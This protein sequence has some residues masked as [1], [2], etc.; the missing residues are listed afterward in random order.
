MDHRAGETVLHKVG[1]GLGLLIAE[2]AAGIEEE[3]PAFQPVS[4]PAAIGISKPQPD[5][6]FQ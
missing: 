5:P 3:V 6:A 4:R 1:D 2:P